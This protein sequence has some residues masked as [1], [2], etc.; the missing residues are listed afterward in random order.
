M[1]DR[2]RILGKLDAL[3]GY[4]RELAD[5]APAR[6]EEYL[7]LR[8]KRR[9]CERILQVSVE[10]VIDICHLLVSGL[11]LGLPAGEEDIFDK[12]AQARILPEEIL[13]IARRMRRF[14]NILVHEYG[15]ID[16]AIVFRLAVTAGHDFGRVRAAVLKALS[17][18][19]QR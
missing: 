15:E 19:E 18:G 3:E 10:C 4:E 9:A 5:T 13:D 17:K 11:R 2:D 8:E 12:L 7:A 14:R 1:L 16:H 6:Y